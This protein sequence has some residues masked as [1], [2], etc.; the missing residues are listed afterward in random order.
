MILS[1]GAYGVSL[2]NDCKYGYDIKD[3][4]MRLTLIKSGTYPNPDADHE[5]T[6]SIYPHKNTWKEANTPMHAYNINVPMY[7]VFE[8]AHES[9]LQREMSLLEVNRENCIVEVLKKAESSDGIIIRLYEYKNMRENMDMVFGME[10]KDAYECDLME[11]VIKTIGST[12]NKISFEMMPYEIKTF[13]INF[14]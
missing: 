12:L 3:G 9:L 13:L 10:I 5:F 2:I 8:E 4:V 7:A 11:N 1:E 14:K 6:Y